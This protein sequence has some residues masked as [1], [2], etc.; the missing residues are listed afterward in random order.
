M[1]PEADSRARHHATGAPSASQRDR[2]IVAGLR[3]ALAYAQSILDTV[4]EPMLIIDA[5][6]HVQSASRA[7]YRSFSVTARSRAAG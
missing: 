4:R 3:K 2:N 7:F 6:L 5:T 1:N